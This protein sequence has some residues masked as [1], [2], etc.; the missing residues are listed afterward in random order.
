[1]TRYRFNLSQ[2]L[3]C[4][5]LYAIA[6]VLCSSFL[7]FSGFE[8]QFF[9]CTRTVN[10]PYAV[11]NARHDTGFVSERNSGIECLHA[12]LS[13]CGIDIAFFF[14]SPILINSLRAF[15]L[16]W[17]SLTGF[18]FFLS[19]LKHSSHCATSLIVQVFFSFFFLLFSSVT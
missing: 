3:L 17:K 18:F 6:G 7:A 15:L 14:Q 13:R 8:A 1:M 4:T 5:P 12:S 2:I 16:G 10:S 19:P 11:L 9:S